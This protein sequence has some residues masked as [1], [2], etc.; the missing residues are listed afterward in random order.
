MINLRVVGAL[1]KVVTFDRNLRLNEV[2]LIHV[3]DENK[4]SYVSENLAALRAKGVDSD[5][6]LALNDALNHRYY[7]GWGRLEKPLIRG[8]NRLADWL[9]SRGARSA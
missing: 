2:R 9:P 3:R 1:E 7:K 4:T 5:L 6:A 8:L